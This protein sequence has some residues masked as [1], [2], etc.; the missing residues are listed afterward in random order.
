MLPRAALLE[1]GAH[2]NSLEEA[3]KAI[4][5]FAS[6]IAPAILGAESATGFQQG[7]PGSSIAWIIAILIA[8]SIGYLL[9]SSRKRKVH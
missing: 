8:G 4:G 1:V 2:T 7:S 5:L 6:A 3:E 9:V